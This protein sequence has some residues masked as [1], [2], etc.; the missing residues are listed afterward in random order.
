MSA[1]AVGPSLDSCQPPARGEDC[2]MDLRSLQEPIKT[3]YRER[4][5]EAR[6]SLSARE[7]SALAN[8]SRLRRLSSFRWTFPFSS[9]Y[10]ARGGCGFGAPVVEG[11]RGEATTAEELIAVYQREASFSKPSRLRFC[12]AA[13]ARSTFGSR[14][15]RVK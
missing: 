14:T 7:R 6:I 5:D 1:A 12:G 10:C 9:T 8:A 13:V 11:G 4:P 3:S 15:R 2:Q